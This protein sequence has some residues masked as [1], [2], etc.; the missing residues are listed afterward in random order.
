[1]GSLRLHKEKHDLYKSPSIV[2]IVKLRFLSSVHVV[3][4]RDKK[5]IL[6]CW[7]DP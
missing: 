2:R 7:S 5:H 6:K 4:M 3:C 1:V